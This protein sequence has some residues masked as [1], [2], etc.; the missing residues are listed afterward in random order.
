MLLQT[1]KLLLIALIIVAPL[2]LNPAK[3]PA[4]YEIPKSLFVQVLL[5]TIITLEMVRR[6]RIRWPSRLSIQM[7]ITAHWKALLLVAILILTTMTSIAPET[8]LWGNEF[9][10]QGLVFHLLLV[11]LWLTLPTLLTPKVINAALLGLVAGSI[12]QAVYA[13]YQFIDLSS[14]NREAAFA[15]LYVNGTFGQAN[16]F[17]GYM[18]VAMLT[19]I[20]LL[21]HHWRNS[22]RKILLAVT[23]VLTLSLQLISLIL[24]FS[25]GSWLFAGMAVGIVMLLWLKQRQPLIAIFIALAGVAAGIALGYYIILTDF[26]V[27]I[28]HTA[29]LGFSMSPL[30]GFGLDAQHHVLFV[31][32]LV[33]DRAHNLL[34]D[35]LITTG[36]TGAIALSI[37]VW[38][39]AKTMVLQI[40]KERLSG[41]QVILITLVVI[42]IVRTM[43]HTS[44]AVNILYLITFAGIWYSDWLSSGKDDIKHD[45]GA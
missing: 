40:W 10:Y 4:G 29:L 45:Q 13:I 41:R 6:F 12:F 9:R 25:A 31:D 35:I 24:S 19:G 16:F 38:K 7:T 30:V 8:A 1:E 28:W 36:I 11:A 44:S 23:V 5:A 3:L 34:L 15:G 2:V 14:Y 17:G 26:R 18:L 22:Q 27:N 39:P 32:G 21:A 37:F 42:Q 20:Y 43:L 33:A